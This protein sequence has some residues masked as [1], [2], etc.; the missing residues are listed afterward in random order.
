M[1]LVRR[2]FIDPLA[3]LKV[4]GGMKAKRRWFRQVWKERRSGNKLKRPNS[5]WRDQY[6]R[7]RARVIHSAGFRRLQAKTQVLG[8]GEGDFHR[9]RLTHS[10]EA[11]QIGRGI[12]RALQENWIEQRRAPGHREWS[13][14]LPSLNSI[15][16]IALAHDIGHPPFGH[17]G[18]IALNYAMRKHGGFE[19]NGQT[20]RLLSKLEA[21][22][23]GFGLDLTR[24]SLLGV[25]KYP[26]AYER[27]VRARPP[28]VQTADQL[29]RDSWKPPKCYMSSEKDVVE[30]ILAPFSSE[31][32]RTFTK[33][34]SAP[35]AA[36]HGKARYHAL[37][38]S[39]MELADDIAYGVHD[40]ED[41]IALKLVTTEELQF[42]LKDMDRGWAEKLKVW[43]V[44][45]LVCLLCSMSGHERKATIGAMVNAFIVSIEP[46]Q[47]EEFSHPLLRLQVRLNDHAKQ[48]LGAIKNLITRRV[49]K[50]AQVQTLEYRG[51]QLVLRMCEAI[52][53]D[54]ERL[55]KDSFKNLWIEAGTRGDKMRVLCD[56]ISGMTD[57]YA[58][59][60]YERLFVPRQGHVFDRL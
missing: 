20:L 24:R 59:R 16:T 52:A 6:G 31:D 49:I 41:A 32:R 18:E 26:V 25:L 39:I 51:Q 36:S 19:G 44:E 53:S 23:Y 42:T 4:G 43:P 40:L 30:W 17:G 27:V 10:M 60:M 2:A 47:L 22:T 34:A 1:L 9:T 35:R 50:T 55:L 29:K 8:I 58:T 21:H 14:W 56:Y 5:E 38:T 46:Y 48:L 28:L 33:L 57:E 45:R 3:L 15:E 11:A 7:D 12:V 54:P 37:D 13:E